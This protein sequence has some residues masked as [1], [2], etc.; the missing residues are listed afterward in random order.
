MEET[1][2]KPESR[3]RS[4]SPGREFITGVRD[5]LPLLLGVV[6]FGM[7]Y[8]AVAVGA[9]IPTAVAQG[10]SSIVFAGSSQFIAAQLIGLGAPALVIIVTVFVVNLRHALYSASI[11]PHIKQ[12]SAGWK[13]VLSYLLTDEAYATTIIHYLRSRDHTYSH[14]YF[15]GAG[16]ALW[17]SWQMSTALGIFAG[18]QIPSSLPLDFALPVTFIALVVPALRDHAA[19]AAAAAAGAL[20]VLAMGMPY[21]LGLIVAAIVG[22]VVG[23]LVEGSR[24]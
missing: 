10:M 2:T 19:V 13:V 21:Q 20:G 6:P 9:G 11:A 4:S 8:G 17:T 24:R 7:I 22:L 12:L 15:L 23:L 3:P 5:L 14:W 18:A 16:L 1:I